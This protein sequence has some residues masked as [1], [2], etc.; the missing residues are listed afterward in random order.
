MILQRNPVGVSS[1]WSQQQSVV[2]S[3]YADEVGPGKARVLLSTGDPGIEI[4][5]FDLGPPTH[6]RALPHEPNKH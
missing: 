5:P 1:S 4:Q 3:L 2:V 6:S